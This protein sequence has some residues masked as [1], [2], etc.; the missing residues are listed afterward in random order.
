MDVL[1]LN[2]FATVRMHVTSGI[3]LCEA[4]GIPSGLLSSP[5]KFFSSNKI[6]TRLITINTRQKRRLINNNTL[7]KLQQKRHTSSIDSD[8]QFR[9]VSFLIITV[10]IVQRFIIFIFFL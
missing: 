5:G 6:N 8:Q 3:T 4:D 9:R 2:K 10:L 1:E 7:N